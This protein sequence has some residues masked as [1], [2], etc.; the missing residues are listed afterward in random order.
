MITLSISFLLY[1]FFPWTSVVSEQRA[2]SAA[3][4]RDATSL[5]SA[6]VCPAPPSTI[7]CRR[8]TGKRPPAGCGR[9]AWPQH[10]P[11]VASLVGEPTPPPTVAAF[12]FWQQVR[13]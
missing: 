13:R 6:A 3:R 1:F 4:D 10:V 9:E 8:R 7:Q 12:P 2:H 11:R 5:W